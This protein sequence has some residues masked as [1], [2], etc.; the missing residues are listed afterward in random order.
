[1]KQWI[2]T[3]QST[4]SPAWP[5][6]RHV[7]QLKLCGTPRHPLLKIRMVDALRYTHG[8]SIPR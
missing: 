6:D 4:S 8:P 3:G 7:V 2:R 5:I 1:M